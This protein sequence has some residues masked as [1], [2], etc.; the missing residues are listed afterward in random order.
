MGQLLSLDRLALN[1]DWYFDDARYLW[2]GNR[3]SY[4]WPSKQ[5]PHQVTIHKD[6]LVGIHKG[7]RIDIRRWIELHIAGTVIES[8]E[9]RSY[10]V[11]FSDKREWDRSYERGNVWQVF[12]FEFEQDALMFTLAFSEYV[13]NITDLHPD[14]DDEYEKTSYYKNR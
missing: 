2:E 11:Y 10:R 4:Q 7:R 9:N 6:D 13:K 3:W 14:K 8:E 12:H 5:F 1:P